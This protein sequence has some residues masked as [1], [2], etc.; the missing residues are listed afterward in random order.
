MNRN[1]APRLTDGSIDWDEVKRQQ[2][3]KVDDLWDALC[4]ARRDPIKARWLEIP[5]TVRA[6]RWFP[7]K[8][9]RHE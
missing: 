6:R 4:E 3:K 7:P 5:L 2:E 1:K 9:V 8:D